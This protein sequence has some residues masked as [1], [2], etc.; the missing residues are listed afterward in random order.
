MFFRQREEF[1]AVFGQQFFV[2][3]YDVF[4]VAHGLEH[5]LFGDTGA[6]EEFHDNIDFGMAHDF[7]RV[8]RY[9][10]SVRAEGAGFGFVARRHHKDIDPAPEAAGDF[11]RVAA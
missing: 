5:Q 9:P 11:R 10:R 1:A 6:A 2:G 3:G 8:G 4:A 7:K